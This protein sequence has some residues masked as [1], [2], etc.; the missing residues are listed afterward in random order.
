MA[1]KSGLNWL[2][3][4]FPFQHISVIQKAADM[5]IL[6]LISTGEGVAMAD[7]D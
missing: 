3:A 2:F 4:Y 7:L 6:L 5:D 1:C